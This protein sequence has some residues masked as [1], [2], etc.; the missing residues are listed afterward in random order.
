MAKPCGPTDGLTAGRGICRF[1]LRYFELLCAQQLPRPVKLSLKARDDREGRRQLPPDLIT[2]N[3]RSSS[4]P[5][6]CPTPLQR[7]HPP[8]NFRRSIGSLQKTTVQRTHVIFRHSNNSQSNLV[9]QRGNLR[10]CGTQS[11]NPGS[12]RRNGRG[13]FK[14]IEHRGHDC[15]PV[16]PGP[17]AWVGTSRT[18]PDGERAHRGRYAPMEADG[19]LSEI[20]IR[21]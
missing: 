19:R 4:K 11:L 2:G 7:L 1:A 17:R 6:H 3:S 13:A 21:L 9:R 20:D 18:G 5:G 15:G 16:V 12:M 14:P 8:A 10:N